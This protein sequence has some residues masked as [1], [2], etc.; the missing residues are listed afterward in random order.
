MPNTMAAT[1]LAR[2][3]F[4]AWMCLGSIVV[5]VIMAARRLYAIADQFRQLQ[6]RKSW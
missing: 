6:G 1:W 3:S 2:H 5:D 4:Q